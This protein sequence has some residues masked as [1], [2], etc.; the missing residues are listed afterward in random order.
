MSTWPSC[1]ASMCRFLSDR[2]IVNDAHGIVRAIV[3]MAK[4]LGM[5]TV[6]EVSRPRI[7]ARG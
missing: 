3:Q 7:T 6:A 1:E 2:R 4:R 5:K